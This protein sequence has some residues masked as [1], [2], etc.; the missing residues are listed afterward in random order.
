MS[1]LEKLFT[2]PSFEEA[3]LAHLNITR[4]TVEEQKRYRIEL[5]PMPGYSLNGDFVP[6]QSVEFT[7]SVTT[8]SAE[9]PV[10]YEVEAIIERSSRFKKV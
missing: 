9:I 1:V 3:N 7:L 4:I 10:D 8:R 2:G 6:L 5:A